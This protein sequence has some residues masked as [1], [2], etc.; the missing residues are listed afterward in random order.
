MRETEKAAE[1]L[2]QAADLIET[3][4]HVKGQF[5]AVALNADG[6]V[7]EFL[8]Y[9]ALGALSAAHHRHTDWGIAS[10]TCALLTLSSQ[11]SR[12]FGSGIIPHWNDDPVRTPGEVIDTFKHAAKELRNEA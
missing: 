3:A 6:E 4:G 1:L 11:V 12:D 8:G 10:Y 5:S 7:T 9:C 2:E